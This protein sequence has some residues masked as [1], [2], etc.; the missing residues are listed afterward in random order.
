MTRSTIAGTTVLVLFA[1][2][3]SPRSANALGE[4]KYVSTSPATGDFVLAAN[5]KV[6]SLVVSDSDWPGVVRAVGDLGQDAGRVTGHDAPVIKSDAPAADE[7]VLIGTIGKSPL[8]DSL[9]KRHKLDVSGIRRPVGVGRDDGGGA[10]HG[11]GAAGTCDR[12]RG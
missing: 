10:P 5:G 12:R 3:L 6:V 7:V 1:I 4:P 2:A 9:I 8:I 11:R